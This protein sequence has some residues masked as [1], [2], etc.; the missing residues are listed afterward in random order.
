[1]KNDDLQK[2]VAGS[3]LIGVSLLSGNATLLSVAGGVGVNW[4]SEGLA[5]LWQGAVG[6]RLAP[7]TPLARA[8]EQ[9]LRARVAR[10]QQRYRDQVDAKSDLKAFR[11][12]AESASSVA[13]AHNPAGVASVNTAQE[14]LARGLD[15]LLFGHD[16][17]Q[18]HWIKAHLLEAAAIAFQEEL[19]SNQEAWQRFHGWLIQQTLH[20]LAALRQSLESLPEVIAQLRSQAVAQEAPGEALARLE[21][22]LRGLRDEI[23]RLADR[24]RLPLAAPTTTI[25]DNRGMSAGQV[26]QTAGNRYN[27]SAHAEGA[28]SQAIVFNL[29]KSPASAEY[30]PLQP[31]PLV[32]LALF[33]NAPDSKRLEL[34]QEARVLQECLQPYG[35]RFDLKLLPA[36]TV[37]DLSRGLLRHRPEIVHFSGHSTPGGLLFERGDG[38]S[39]LVPREA[40]VRELTAHVP[41]LRCAILNACSSESHT[42]DLELGVPYVIAMRGPLYD[43]A[44]IEFTR[45]F[46]DALAAGHGI[47]LAYET[48][49]NRI[50]LKDLPDGEIPVLVRSGNAA[51]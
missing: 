46:Y 48:G 23:R 31:K 19:A 25:F 39:R 17:R 9:A 43:A 13:Q 15:G 47:L 16:E 30:T 8:Y 40:L 35:P 44:A 49:Y 14:A 29:S 33:A 7:G 20:N 4:S 28:G 21:A 6:P 22:E 26:E 27:Q 34:L 42:V 1:M 38:R 45:G 3:L 24:S 12:L 50:R 2:V 11:L 10:L 36:G 32:I 37:D 51:S 18:V 41:P 5:G